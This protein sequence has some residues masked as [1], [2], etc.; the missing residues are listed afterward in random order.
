MCVHI[1]VLHNAVGYK[2]RRSSHVHSLTDSLTHSLTY[3]LTH[4]LTHTLTHTLTHL[5]A[6]KW[7][8]RWR[9][10]FCRVRTFLSRKMKR[11]RWTTPRTEQHYDHICQHQHHE[12]NTITITYIHILMHSCIY[13][14]G[15]HA[16][17]PISSPSPP[18][19]PP[20]MGWVLCSHTNIITTMNTSP[21]L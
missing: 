9:S 15:Y 12:Q 11:R 7:Y 14:C 16:H 10:R 6:L 5:H 19:N 8:T 13:D 4:S 3:S 17:T 1:L 18:P 21:S 20:S 2:E